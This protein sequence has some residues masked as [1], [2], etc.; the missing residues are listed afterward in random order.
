MAICRW[1]FYSTGITSHASYLP[2]ILGDFHAEHLDEIAGGRMFVLKKANNTLRPIVT[3]SLW[4]RCA[5]RLGDV[6]VRSNV[7]TFFMSQYPNFIQFGSESDG[8]TRCAQVTQLL[9]AAWAQHSEEN[10]L[11]M[12]QL[13]IVNAYP[14]AD[15][16]AQFD[17]L[18]G[19]ASKSYDSRHVHMR[20]AIPC[21]SSLRPYWSYFESM[22]GT[23]ST[24]HFSDYEGQA[25]EIACSEGGQQG[26]AF[27]TVRFAVTTFPS[28]GR[29]FARHAACTGAAICDDVFI[30]HHLQKVLLLLLRSNRYSSRILISTSMCPS[31]IASFW[32]IELTTTIMHELF[33]KM[34][35]RPILSSHICQAWMQA[36]A[37]RG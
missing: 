14:S 35:C 9:A 20:D 32:V 29:V 7:A 5:P 37:R 24:L 36:S 26:D 16:Q 3:G 22:Q 34:L 33:F 17:V 28:F 6:E 21:P 12:I 30:V 11:I 25:H 13:D 23:A 2:N 27:E 4:R 8:A 1:R 19:R 31:S 15:R 10:P 18:A